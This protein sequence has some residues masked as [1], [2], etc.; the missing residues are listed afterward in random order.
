MA[1]AAR[2]PES[3]GVSASAIP[4]ARI[5]PPVPWGPSRPLCP[6]KASASI[7]ISSISMGKVPAVWAQS[8]KNFSPCSRQK[9][10]TRATGR[11]VPQ[12][13]LAWVMT[14]SRVSRRRQRSSSPG[15]SEP[16][17]SHRAREKVHPVCSSWTRGRMTALCS[18][19]ETMT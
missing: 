13:L 17:P 15:S 9:A 16:V 8:T 18:M 1:E 11:R 3:R 5:K 14:T 19:A 2:P 4:S 7:F 12:T 6:V 10:P